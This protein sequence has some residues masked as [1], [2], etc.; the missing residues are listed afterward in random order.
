MGST[1]QDS[2]LRIPPKLVTFFAEGFLDV[3]LAHRTE[4]VPFGSAEEGEDLGV[5]DVADG[6]GEAGSYERQVA[7]LAE[8]V[9]HR[10]GQLSQLCYLSLVDLVEGDEQAR[11]VFLEKVGE[12]FDLVAKA[13]LDDVLLDLGPGQAARLDSPSRATRESCTRVS[14]TGS[15]R[16]IA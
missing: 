13:H 3:L 6:G 9:L 8:G 12:Q 7:L 14:N 16:H 10:R 15:Y 1:T 2:P 5:E 11:L 4:G